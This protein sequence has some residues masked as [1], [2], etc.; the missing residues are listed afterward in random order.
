MTDFKLCTINVKGLRDKKKRHEY[1]L[2]LREKSFSVYFLQ[3]TH[4]VLND[5]KCWNNEWGTKALWCHGT[6]NSR[7]TAILFHSKFDFSIIK[8]VSDPNGRFIIV[9]INVSGKIFTLVN[10]Y[11]PNDDCPQFFKEIDKQLGNFQCDAIA[12]GGDFNCVLNLTLDKKGGRLQTNF[13]ART[14]IMNLMEKRCLIDIW[15]NMHPNSRVYTWRSNTDPPIMCRLDYFLISKTLKACVE[16]SSIVYGYR[17]DHKLVSIELNDNYEKSGPGFWKFNVS[18][19][20]DISYINMVKES[21]KHILNENSDANPQILWETIKCVIRGD[22]I[23]YSVMKAKN[24]NKKQENLE[25]EITRLE[26]LYA[27]K[28]DPNTLVTMNIKKRELE[29]LYG[30]KAKGAMIRSKSRWIEDGEKNSSYF[31]NLEKH[32]FS[33]KCITKLQKMDG[34]IVTG[35]G[36]VLEEEVKFYSNLYSSCINYDVDKN[37]LDQIGIAPDD[38]PKVSIEEA[39]LC[40]GRITVGECMN[41][42][43]TTPNGKSPGPDGYPVEFYKM[44]WNQI[45]SVLVKSFNYSFNIGQLSVSQRRGVISLIPKDGKNEEFLQNWRPI[46]LLNVDYK[47]AAKVIVNRLKTV[48]SSIISSDQ[49]GFLPNRYIGE[50]VRLVLDIIEY[51][52]INNLPGTLFFIDFEKAY[53]KLEWCFVQKCFDLFGFGNDIKRWI[54]LFYTQISSCVINNGYMSNYFQLSRGVHQGCPLSCYIFILCAELMGIAIRANNNI[55]GIQI[56]NDNHVKITQ[57]ADD[58]TLILDGSKESINNAVKVINNFGSISGLKL[59][60]SKSVFL[61]IGS[62]KNDDMCILPDD[63]YQCTKG[64][65]KFL[66]VMISLDKNELLKINYEPQFKKLSTVLDIWSQRDLTPIGKI[67]IIKSLALSQMT[68]LLSVLPNPQPKF[69]K[70]IEQ[71]LFKFIWNGKPDKVKRD[72]MYCKKEY[73]GL[74]MTNIPNFIHALKISWVKRFLNDQN[75]G[76]WKCLFSNELLKV[77]G[78]WIWLCNPKTNINFDYDIICNQFLCDVLRSWYKLRNMDNQEIDEVLW[79]NSKIKIN[80]KTIYFKSWSSKGVN[81]ISDL[82]IEKHWMSYQ[83]FNANYGIKCNFLKYLSVVNAISTSFKIQLTDYKQTQDLQL[84]SQLKNVK[85][86]SSFA[87]QLLCESNKV[88]PTAQHRWEVDLDFVNSNHIDWSKIYSMPY[89]CTIETR[90]HYFQFRFIHMILPTNVFLYKI[91]K[92]DDDLCSFC[93]IEKETLNHL[94]WSCNCVSL[95][96][97]EIISWLRDLNIIINISYREICLGIYDTNHFAFINMIIIFAKK[98][99]YKCRVQEDILLFN[100]FKEWIFFMEKIEKQIAVNK[101]K[102]GVH[103]KKM[104]ALIVRK[105]IMPFFLKHFKTKK[106][107][108]I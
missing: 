70:K 97:K 91:G 102:C 85:K 42:I 55:K 50:N 43:T 53:D 33:K 16:N 86:A 28:S 56:G 15:R 5:V 27:E 88:K 104:G 30:Y 93:K 25:K 11:A 96:W 94:M 23:R 14:E 69:I 41:A 1:F 32:H 87:Y 107:S 31:F 58:T 6:S 20:S 19:L 4:T 48:L 92:V 40:E 77:G 29:T 10:I 66:G 57:F 63:S 59:N 26:M 60:S 67:T 75:K 46:S 105:Q 12:F 47:V 35:S 71:T 64:P 72:V 83:E 3:E 22:T 106:S 78:E 2:W 76:S 99:I 81:F 52:D 108:C 100:D 18:L 73:G 7:G 36:P 95:F 54:Q 84:L 68:Y 80:G 61:K 90:S 101:D 62:L 51:A 9:D 65:V 82:I 13:K 79:Y 103:I 98:F 8:S 34:N 39:Q 24:R 49:T 21:I 89:K 45:G 17:T 74:K 44:F 38:I 37:I